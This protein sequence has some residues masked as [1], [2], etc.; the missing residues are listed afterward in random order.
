MPLGKK[1]GK[2]PMSRKT[3]SKS[4]SVK[5]GRTAPKYKK[6]TAKTKLR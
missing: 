2:A 5:N 6:G 1:K 3:V 4:N